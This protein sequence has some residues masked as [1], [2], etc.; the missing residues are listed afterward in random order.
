[1]FRL[2]IL[3]FSPMAVSRHTRDVFERR[4]AGLHASH[5][6]DLLRPEALSPTYH[7][8]AGRM[9]SISELHLFFG[10]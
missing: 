8:L 7:D 6:A 3:L 4:G 10:L 9:A 2:F 5:I 1:M